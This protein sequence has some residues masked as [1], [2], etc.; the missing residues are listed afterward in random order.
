MNDVG[1]FEPADA[2]DWRRWL[3]AHHTSEPAIWVVYRKQSSPDPN[4]TW[5][6]AVD[7][8]LCYGWID[9]KAQRLDEER[10]EQYFTTRRAGSGWS[11]INKDKV[12]RLTEEGRLAPAGLAAIERAKEDGS[13]RAL[14]DVEAL[15]SPPD[16]VAA[17]DALP[18]AADRFAALPR[19]VRRNALQL[20]AAAKR[21][22]TRARR[23]RSTIEQLPPDTH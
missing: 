1:R 7:E 17:L 2:A 11:K 18:G 14:D 16:L 19:S 22:E 12:A 21:P 13:W 15:V 8:A 10:Y 20:I 5:G 3:D 4:L 6:Q 9:S 23:I